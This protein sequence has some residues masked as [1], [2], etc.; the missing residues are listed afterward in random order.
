MVIVAAACLSCSGC[1]YLQSMMA[2]KPQQ[3]DNRTVLTGGDGMVF[4]SARDLPRFTC[5][6]ELLLVC[7]TFGGPQYVCGCKLP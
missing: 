4:I 2:S 6:P 7:E 5:V 1:S 3:A